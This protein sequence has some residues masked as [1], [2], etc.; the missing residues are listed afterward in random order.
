ME[1]DDCVFC[2]IAQHAIPAKIFFENEDLLVI[3]DILP[4]APVHVLVISRQHIPSLASMDDTQADLLGKM[5]MAAKKV[6]EEQGI[7]ESGYRLSINVGKQGGQV[8]PHL[9][10]HVLGGKQL[11]E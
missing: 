3:Q 5:V 11:L 8:V 7:A 2:N 1:T 4:K 6:A 10:M 9:H